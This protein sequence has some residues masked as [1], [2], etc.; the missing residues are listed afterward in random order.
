MCDV[1]SM[2]PAD[3]DDVVSWISD[4]TLTEEGVDMQDRAVASIPFEHLYGTVEEKKSCGSSRIAEVRIP[5]AV[6]LLSRW[7]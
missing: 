7:T 3:A 4:V 2:L 1:A 5:V 6:K